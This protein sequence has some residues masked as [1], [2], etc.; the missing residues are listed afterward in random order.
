MLI[1]FNIITFRELEIDPTLARRIVR[2]DVEI[3][4]FMRRGVGGFA[5]EH[6]QVFVFPVLL[7]WII[8]SFKN[9]KFYFF[10]GVIWVVSYVLLILNSQRNI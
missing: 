9:H 5:L 8:K 1:V 7:A 6:M 4:P 3:Y 10:I 2:A